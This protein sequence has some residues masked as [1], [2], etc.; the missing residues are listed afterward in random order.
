MFDDLKGK[1]AGAMGGDLGKMAQQALAIKKVLS[2]MTTTVKKDGVEIVIT[3]DQDIQSVKV[4][5]NDD[6][7]LRTAFNEAIKKSQEMAAKEMEGMM[8]G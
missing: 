3:G 5:G 4:D 1:L 6:K 2:Q 7:R 8:K